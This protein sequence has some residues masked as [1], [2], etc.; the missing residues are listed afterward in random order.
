[1]QSIGRS[2]SLEEID[3]LIRSNIPIGSSFSAAIRYL[4]ANQIEFTDVKKE[5]KI[6]AIIRNIKG[7][8]I[9][10]KSASI[11]IKYN[12]FGNVDRIEVF[13]SYL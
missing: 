13:A 12:I 9:I 4:S 3:E 7:S 5:R 1:M 8:F 11:R 6:Y 2:N 10:S